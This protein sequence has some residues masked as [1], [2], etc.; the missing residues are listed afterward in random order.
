MEETS[1]TI[2][3]TKEKS[4]GFTLV[5]I[6]I[7]VAVIGIIAMV[8][9]PKYQG[10]TDH[11]HLESSAQM[12][13]GKLRNAKQYA[14]DRRTNVYVLLNSNSAQIFYFNDTT[15]E[16]TS[17]ETKDDFDR[18]VHFAYTSGTGLETIPS[19]GGVDNIPLDFDTVEDRCLIFDRKGFLK[20]SPV[21]IT[22]TNSRSLP[23]SVSV[24]LSSDTLEVKIN[25]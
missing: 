7:V 9:V 20:T 22:L 3:R 6:M 13:A 24:D 10:L 2:P 8:S 23:Q 1:V 18:G 25:W 19:N 4:L 12:L 14:M 21:S 17:L 16:Y 5:E 15:K 11:Y